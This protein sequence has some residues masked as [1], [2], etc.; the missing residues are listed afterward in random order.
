M[1]YSILQANSLPSVSQQMP[2]MDGIE[3]CRN[4]NAR[5]GGHSKAKVVFVTAHVSGSFEEEC[6]N[7][8]AV[9]FLSKP[10]NISDVEKCLQSLA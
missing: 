7:A 1:H 5:Q 6:L 8:G 9:A 4:I 2:V 3:A 10:C